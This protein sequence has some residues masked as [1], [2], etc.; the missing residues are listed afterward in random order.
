LQL[1]P[2]KGRTPEERVFIY[3]NGKQA[4]NSR[5]GPG[6]RCASPS[7]LAALALP[8][9]R[10]RARVQHGQTSAGLAG[11]GKQGILARGSPGTRYLP[12][13]AL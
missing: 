3:G 6:V 4:K 13:I 10:V 5:R 1:S 9:G 8:G 2:D 7:L 11:R 12:G